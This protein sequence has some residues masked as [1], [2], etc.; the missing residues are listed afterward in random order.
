MKLSVII[1]SV[2][3]TT[4]GSAIA[5]IQRQTFPDWEVIVI[6]QGQDRSVEAVATR[7]GAEDVRIRYQHISQKGTSRARNAGIHASEGELVVFMDDDCEADAKLLE[8]YA[9]LFAQQPGVGFAGGSLI[10]SEH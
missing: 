4:L 2:R 9:D 6:G 1:P 7:M 10:S 3:A 8:V 5:S